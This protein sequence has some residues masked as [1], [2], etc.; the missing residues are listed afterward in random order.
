MRDENC[1]GGYGGGASCTEVR[2]RMVFVPI[3]NV[4]GSSLRSSS[5]L[6]FFFFTPSSAGAIAVDVASPPPSSALASAGTIAVD[7]ASPFPASFP[8][9]IIRAAT[10]EAVSP[11]SPFIIAGGGTPASTP[12]VICNGGGGA[13]MSE[14]NREWGWDDGW[15]GAKRRAEGY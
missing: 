11:S 3:A 6:T 8:S 13:A 5:D 1:C 2:A 10:S 9:V 12:S 14:A 7:A 4:V 15:R